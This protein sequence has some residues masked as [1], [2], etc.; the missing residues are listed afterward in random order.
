[1]FR[2]GANSRL[3]HYRHLEDFGPTPVASTKQNHG[4]LEKIQVSVRLFGG[5]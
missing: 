4:H 2:S 3:N 1:M 5:G